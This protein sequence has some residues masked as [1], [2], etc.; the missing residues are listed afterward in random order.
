M[1][2]IKNQFTGGKMNKDLDE[3]LIP[4]GEYR[5]AMNI[6]VS[7]SEGSDVG[8]VQNILGNKRLN[9][10]GCNTSY[11]PTNAFTVGS[12]SDEKND[13]FYWL[14][15]GYASD[16]TTNFSNWGAVN[17]IADYIVR[18]GGAK[19]SQN[20]APPVPGCDPVFVDKYAFSTPTTSTT[21]SNFLTGIPIDI[22]SE[23]GA[24]WG[25]AGVMS[26]GTTSPSSA[27]LYSSIT[28][29]GFPVNYGFSQQAS[30]SSV[31]L[32]NVGS[33][34]NANGGGFM[35]PMSPIF[36]GGWA[37]QASNVVYVSSQVNTTAM[38][39][40]EITILPNA[41][42]LLPSGTTITG[43]TSTTLTVPNS[44]GGQIISVKKLDLSNN[45]LGGVI[46]NQNTNA[47]SVL[48]NGNA[49]YSYSSSGVDING[50]IGAITST[51][52]S[53]GTLA[54]N[55][56]DFDTSS[57]T[58]GDLVTL[59]GVQ[60]CIG[61]IYPYYVPYSPAAGQELPP[62]NAITIFECGT[63]NIIYP[64]NA[65]T[66]P[67]QLDS[68]DVVF[69][70]NISI[71]LETPLDLSSGL[72][73][74]LFFKGPRTLNFEHNQLITGIN[75]V[76]DMLFWTDN[77]TE[78]KKINITRSI[79]GT[80]PSG[81]QHTKLINTSQGYGGWYVPSAKTPIPAREE[82]ITVIK[83]SPDN[84]PTIIPKTSI[85]QDQVSG[86]ATG[87]VFADSSTGLMLS[88]GDTITITISSTINADPP[89]I[90]IGDI[91][92]LQS[93]NILGLVPPENYEVRVRVD[94]V[95]VSG[96]SV[97]VDVT[98]V[99]ISPST[100]TIASDFRVAVSEEGYDLFSRKFPRFAY[101]YKYED[102]EYSS[103]GPYSDVVFLPGHFRYHPTEAYNKG[104][105]N[106]LKS[107]TLKDFVPTNIPEDV[108]QVDLLFRDETSAN[109]YA[110]K[111]IAATDAIWTSE[112]S[113][114]GS[115]GSYEVSTENIYA[116]LPA[117][118]GLRPWDNVPRLSLG[119]EVAGSRLIYANYLQGYELEVSPSITASVEIRSLADGGF[120]GQRSVKSLRTY[121]VGIVYG[122]KYGRETPVFTN[123]E[124][125]IILPKANAD[126]ASS[127]KV[128]VD[129]QH[130]SWAKY[131]K[132]FVKE[133]SN[134]YYNLALGRT[135]DAEDGNIWLA[136]PS[137][138]RNK[139]D[140]D[141]Y[142]ILKK[143]V[144]KNEV[145]SEKA[146]YKIVAI[147]NEAPDYI[148]TTYT[149]IAKP[150]SWP[151][152]GTN[153]VFGGA[154]AGNTN[155]AP[156]PGALSF[157]IEHDRW[158]EDASNTNRFGM[159]DLL[160]QYQ[161]IGSEEMFVNFVRT[162]NGVA[163]KSK[164]Y[165][166]T[167][168]VIHA[169]GM[170]QSTGLK[171]YEVF[172]SKPF[173]AS[174]SWIGETVNAATRPVFYKAVIK[175]KP[176]FDGRFFVKIENDL[177]ATTNLTPAVVEDTD[178]RVTA[179]APLYYLRDSGA[180]NWTYDSNNSGVGTDETTG[181]FTTKTEGEWKNMLKFGGTTVVG[182]W[183]IDQVSY[184]GTQGSS[185]GVFSAT[186]DNSMVDF[187]SPQTYLTKPNFW[188]A[189]DS[190]AGTSIHNSGT[191]KSRG[192][193]FQNGIA[194]W[195]NAQV[196]E[197]A[198]SS[199]PNNVGID[200]IM[201]LSY[202][203]LNP[204]GMGGAWKVGD[205]ANSYTAHE[206]QFVSQIKAGS[207]FRMADTPG[208]TYTI[209]KVETEK[210]YNHRAGL[211]SP[212][213]GSYLYHGNSDWSKQKWIFDNTNNINKRAAWHIHY[214]IDSDVIADDL[215]TNTAI[216]GTDAFTTSNLQFIEEYD[217]D[218]VEPISQFPA[219]FE[220]EPK[221][222]VDLDIYY[223]ASGKIPT[224]LKDGD[225]SQLIP[226]GS[227]M[228]IPPSVIA[229]FEDG[230]TVTGWGGS[231][232]NGNYKDN[233]VLISPRI[234]FAEYL[235]L[236]PLNPLT[237][238]IFS[239]KTPFGGVS[240]VKFVGVIYELGATLEVT[241]FEVEAIS[242]VGLS[243]FNCWSFGNGVESNRIGD[244]Y[245][246][247]YLTNGAT[248]S[249]TLDKKYGEEK[250]SY[251]LI[252]SGLYNSISGVNDLNQFIA[253][254]KITK[255]IN[256]IHGSIQKLFARDSDL[257]TL[258]EDK[259]LKI[260]VQKDA[261]FNADGNSQL[262]AREG[263]LG[264]AVPFSGEY[265][266]SK[267]PESFA[268]ESYR[269]YFTDKVRGSVMRLSM[270]GLTPISDHG[271]K[272]Y[273]RDNLKLSNKL[274]G[275]YDDRKD[276]Y[277]ITIKDIQKTVSF[278][279]DVRGW[280]SFKSFVAE[281]AISCANEYYT[282]VKGKPWRHHVESVDRNTFHEHGFTNSSLTVLMNDMPGSIKSFKTVNYEGSQT[283]VSRS[284]DANGFIIEDGEYFNLFPEKGWFV[285]S[286]FTDLEKGGVNNF[287]KKE[288]KW[289]GFINGDNVVSNFSG[290]TTS[291][292]DTE[293]FSIQ[294]I[295]MVSGGVAIIEVYG[296][297]N[298][299]AFN[300]N[301]NATIDNNS[302]ILPIFGCI[303]PSAQNY[304]SGADTDDG[305]CLYPGCTDSA[306]IN[307]DTTANIDDGSCIATIYG[308]TDPTAF[309]YY[310]GA[311]VNQVSA[312]DPSDPCEA[313]SYGCMNALAS[314]YSLMWNTP[315]TDAGGG[316]G[317]TAPGDNNICCVIPVVTVLGCTD[318]TGGVPNWTGDWP[319]P[320]PGGQNC[321]PLAN[322][323][324]GSC[325][326]CSDSLADNY[327]GATPIY[328]YGCFF[329]TSP[330]EVLPIIP[331]ITATAIGMEFDMFTQN[332]P[333]YGGY[334]PNVGYPVG[335]TGTPWMTVTETATNTVVYV[336]FPPQ[337]TGATTGT[338][339]DNSSQTFWMS[340]IQTGLSPGT[341]YNFS[342]EFQ[343]NNS[344]SPLVIDI[345]LST[346]DI[347]GCTDIDGSN[348]SGLYPNQTH[349]ACNYNPLA[350]LDDNTCEFTSCEGCT[351]PSADNYLATALFDDGSCTFS[352]IGC[353]DGTQLATACGN[354][355][356][357][358]Y[359]NYN[360][361]NTV[362]GTCVPN[363]EGCTAACSSNYNPNATIDDDCC[364]PGPCPGIS[365]TITSSGS[366]DVK[367]NL[368]ANGSPSC[369]PNSNTGSA[370]SFTPTWGNVFLE[371]KDDQ[372]LVISNS[373]YAPGGT[374]T[375]VQLFTT[376]ISNLA[377][378]GRKAWVSLTNSGLLN[379]QGNTFITIDLSYAS[380]DGNCSITEPTATYTMGCEDPAATNQGSY[381]IT[382]NTQCTYSPIV[383][384]TDDT[385]G[386]GGNTYW[387]S[388]YSVSNTVACT[389]INGGNLTGTVGVD[390][391]ICCTYPGTPSVEF[392][393]QNTAS[394][395][396]AGGKITQ[397]YFR[398]NGGAYQTAEFF[399]PVYVNEHL[400]GDLTGAFS[401]NTAMYVLGDPTGTPYATILAGQVTLS[402]TNNLTVDS[403]N[404]TYIPNKECLVINPSLGSTC[405]NNGYGAGLDEVGDLHLR[406]T[407]R[408]R[409]VLNN[410]ISQNNLIEYDAV[411][412]ISSNDLSQHEIYTVG[413]K[414]DPNGIYGSTWLPNVDLHSPSY[415]IIPLV[416]GCTDN[417]TQINGAGVVNDLHPTSIY[418]PPGASLNYDPLAN[419]AADRD[420][421]THCEEVG[422]V[423]LV[424]IPSSTI[425]VE[426]AKIIFT[427]RC[428]AT[429]Y[430]IEVMSDSGAWD[431]IATVYQP[432]NPS[433]NQSTQQT[434]S[435]TGS[436]VY[437]SLGQGLTQ[438]IEYDFRVKTV[439]TNGSDSTTSVPGTPW[440]Y[441]SWNAIN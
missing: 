79:Q 349:G 125:S 265:G 340:F 159:P 17:T 440:S 356:Y 142:L 232:M 343:C 2:E 47:V 144:D 197:G 182:R 292:F 225:G 360:I 108:V 162:I 240:Y 200:R 211:P 179:S 322:T 370:G 64:L 68:G 206:K 376:V 316:N 252:Y 91:L 305:S 165:L 3:R 401:N 99:S 377:V 38:L 113:F 392:N 62:N 183:F 241:G 244:T 72:F 423:T 418:P 348:A 312:V 380:I 227:T 283:R 311:N 329:C 146:R 163:V 61:V 28:S 236:A 40:A 42:P 180:T 402:T 260:L 272:D 107:L 273:F 223:E 219:I 424:P 114:P 375:G 112:G 290:T 105:V 285:E 228:N 4:K 422:N 121:D 174:E 404:S 230:I 213:H 307:F 37:V 362:A 63:T 25:V 303:D 403:G 218:R 30:I 151:S 139:V 324:D 222:D 354:V 355:T 419:V 39:G 187:N 353:M 319:S 83:K 132:F 337:G 32:S 204:S 167:N 87:V 193:H 438:N 119:Q 66:G 60:G 149:T 397:I 429:K 390:D 85:R 98:L 145:V 101:R 279:E 95:T 439:C 19:F 58:I 212:Y 226:I 275:S 35:I 69:N 10:S 427:H 81:D 158:V 257:L 313:Y 351:D 189:V 109:I 80:S 321:D 59:N 195:S 405:A 75:I 284:L 84:P 289:F 278:R 428:G 384:C 137:V 345:T 221:E 394:G 332:T 320:A 56:S 92:F 325:V 43:I 133:T 82:H 115:L 338:N 216:T 261:L 100:P 188:G 186:T 55:I 365:H 330:D 255:D 406:Y 262:L 291:S 434:I 333:Q 54:F 386:I 26:D 293:D 208:L 154:G 308:C 334:G 306:A 214:T 23:L 203:A 387:A 235:L 304:N 210:L 71:E 164:Y 286:A 238:I 190:T 263:V 436:A 310:A 258:C 172:V 176:E 110:I 8:A 344:F 29:V 103:I 277:N 94:A 134:E 426:S 178:W 116:N 364:L 86:L 368:W 237:D 111:N 135:Y 157:Y 9:E 389:E 407:V 11:L 52:V 130:P 369:Y 383:G 328:D 233:I 185:T 126:L 413:C 89:S 57:L 331:D 288:G 425:F 412:G 314:N 268:S 46:A 34:G 399:G 294:G 246:K 350:T 20:L 299:I 336:G 96:S 416:V 21:N 432:P 347:Y 74:S 248:A 346:L 388:N 161:Q 171:V 411:V 363:V 44:F 166:V 367:Y 117:N 327:D 205:D 318:C 300:F 421:C 13:A 220:T 280:V 45:L 6:Q 408:F 231:D 90:I 239:F 12:V 150:V 207:K 415:C 168:V 254:E 420:C 1:P 266:I 358:K 302:C 270:D 242:K 155:K 251:G 234:S 393:P 78:P 51:S 335:V 215:K 315:C 67:G 281:N 24:G 361:N 256:P 371:V 65:G 192:L 323:D 199:G 140:E 409:A 381:H 297:M 342:F 22:V 417:G 339:P 33:Q 175:N 184:C 148:K 191:G 245:N 118:Q 177:T 50:F 309:N 41:T 73:T 181:R 366:I 5:D 385:P 410:N 169:A 249:T 14:V 269:A 433:F 77:A 196:V 123:K 379:A 136:F 317:G 70:N 194:S 88:Q 374:N 224:S 127:I 357:Y 170:A 373:N 276:E 250:R 49:I 287:I 106:N 264:Q 378:L 102:G 247:P 128:E 217:Q 152:V 16:S 147:E 372:G 382:D 15:S 201:T 282:F 156:T 229:S 326:Y 202:S 437:S 53:D 48:A 93:D 104:M 143:G 341:E 259:C 131:Y 76:D 243:W 431:S 120:V 274:I 396:N 414:Y 301:P 36:G 160:E 138:D 141:T 209:W 395:S 18:Y 441:V 352:I 400:H 391:N 7:T 253:A 435:L 31:Y 295:G 27:I 267:N 124:A 153:A 359:S 398:Q 198:G 430:E 298:P 271:M 173:L 122:D 296:C 97:I 129:T